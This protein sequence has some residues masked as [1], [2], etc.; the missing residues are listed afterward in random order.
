MPR[1]RCIGINAQATAVSNRG[2]EFALAGGIE[3]T[4]DVCRM[5]GCLNRGDRLTAWGSGIGCGGAIGFS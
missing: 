1:E 3:A 2:F 5:T 4:W